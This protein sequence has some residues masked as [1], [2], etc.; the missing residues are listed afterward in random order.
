VIPAIKIYPIEK[1]SCVFGQITRFIQMSLQRSLESSTLRPRLQQNVYWNYTFA[2]GNDLSAE[3]S[4][5]DAK[6]ADRSH[7]ISGAAWRRR[8]RPER[9]KGQTK[10]M[11]TMCAELQQQ[12]II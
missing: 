11:Q 7:A 1:Y 12:E 10:K 2:V 5:E 3:D 8:V 6:P 9:S 4:S